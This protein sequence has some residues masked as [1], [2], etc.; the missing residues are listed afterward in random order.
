M[1]SVKKRQ[2][3]IILSGG[4]T[5][6]SVT[7]LLAVARKL[8][9][10]DPDLRLVFVGGNR[11][12]ERELVAACSFPNHKLD[13]LS[14]PAGKLRRYF[15]WQNFLDI[16]KIFAAFFISLNLIRQERPGVVVGAGSFVSVPLCWA[17]YICR[18]PVVVHQQDVRPGLAN[19]LMA[20]FAR[21]I[22]VVFEKSLRDYGPEAVWIGNP[23][24]EPDESVNSSS[25]YKA[26]CGL[27]PTK[28]FLLITGGG[29]GSVA[30]NELV[31]QS[32]AKLSASAQIMHLTGKGKLPSV[33]EQERLKNYPD[34]HLAELLGSDEVFNL[35]TAADLVVSRCG[36]A[37]LTELSALAKPAILI[38]MPDSH[39][40]DN[41][42]VFAQAKAAVVL[43]QKEIDAAKFS[44]IV[45]QVL[46]DPIRREELS[47]NIGRFMK[48]DGAQ[49]M[50]SFILEILK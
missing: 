14:L 21:L 49:I 17:A 8:W 23:F 6:G 46:H 32:V 10:E 13:F 4:G 37:T 24:N 25:S 34:Y 20:P 26:A 11:G 1:P 30:I 18:V 28:P 41:A 15:A 36:L 27:C 9:L 50:A 29:T 16:F 40:E 43:K 3:T 5:G 31:F 44:E 47:R 2:K 35:M 38:P 45:L 42:I 19:R 22:T 48:K 7:P 39:Q 12:P 33:Q